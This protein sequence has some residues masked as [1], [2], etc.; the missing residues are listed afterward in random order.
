MSIRGH[1]HHRDDSADTVMDPVCGMQIRTYGARTG[2][3][4]RT[5]KDP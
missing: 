1:N 5:A 3:G 2:A 4:R